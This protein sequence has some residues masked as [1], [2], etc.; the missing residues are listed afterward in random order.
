MQQQ[1]LSCRVIQHV[2]VKVGGTSDKQKRRRRRDIYGSIT[3]MRRM[4]K[5]Q[6]TQQKH[7]R[8]VVGSRVANSLSSASTP[9]DVKVLSSVD[10]PLGG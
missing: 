7:T 10:L 2:H 3:A 9:A 6:H 4:N 8:R 5:V 1:D